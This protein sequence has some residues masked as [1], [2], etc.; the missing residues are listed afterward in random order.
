MKCRACNTILSPVNKETYVFCVQCGSANYLSES[1]AVDDNNDYFNN[2]FSNSGLKNNFR[3]LL[4]KVFNRIHYFLNYGVESKFINLI[5]EI[6]QYFATAKVAIEI[7]FGGGGE[8]IKRLNNG[9][10]CFGLDSSIVAVEAFKKRYPHYADR[11]RYDTAENSLIGVDLIY[12]NALFEHLD[13]PNSFLK[14][15]YDQLNREGYLILRLP[16][17][18]IQNFY[19]KEPIDVNFWKPCHRILYTL[20]GLEVILKANGFKIIKQAFLPHFGF[21]VMNCLLS[22][23]FE[24]IMYT[25]CPYYE[26]SG[27]NLRTYINALCSALFSKLIC[28][29]FALIAKKV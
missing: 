27:L 6:D 11:V 10:N 7:G 5:G 22:Y 23:G 2:H 16:L 24:S 18:T 20:N 4:F 26:T 12:S 14:S 1:N 8:L 19:E 29:D 21:K 25:R 13:N 15:S 17:L 3:F 28:Q 9:C